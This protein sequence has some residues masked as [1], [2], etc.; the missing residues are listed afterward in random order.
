MP[1]VEALGVIAITIMVGSYALERRAPVFIA[2]FAGGCALAAL[3]AFLIGAWPFFVAES[4]WAVIA[5][6]RWLTLR[7]SES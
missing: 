3:Y 2:V 1:A 6:R 4:I 5:F 7:R